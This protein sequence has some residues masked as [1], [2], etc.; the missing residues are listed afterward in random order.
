MINW[1]T[2]R[3][4]NTLNTL[5]TA[6]IDGIRVEGMTPQRQPGALERVALVEVEIERFEGQATGAVGMLDGELFAAL[7]ITRKC[8]SDEAETELFD[9]VLEIAAVLQDVRDQ[10][11]IGPAQVLAVEPEAL[12]DS[13]SKRVAAW[14]VSYAQQLRL[15]RTDLPAESMPFTELYAARVPRVGNAH[16]G[17]YERLVP[18]S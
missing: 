7:V 16:L 5:L 11:S 1:N 3:Y 14:R 2:R 12:D 17:D 13:M 9:L 18:K 6:Q 4:I 8:D 10:G 15:Q